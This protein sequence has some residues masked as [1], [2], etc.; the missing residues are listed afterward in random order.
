[1]APGTCRSDFKNEGYAQYY[2]GFL[3]FLKPKKSSRKALM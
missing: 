2:N 1:M 3:Y